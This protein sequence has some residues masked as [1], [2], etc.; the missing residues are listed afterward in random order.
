M[1]LPLGP[2]VT[3]I[4]CVCV[5]GGGAWLSVFPRVYLCLRGGFCW[6]QP[7]Q[8]WLQLFG[9]FLRGC[10]VPCCWCYM[11]TGHSDLAWTLAWT[12]IHIN[13]YTHM[14]SHS[15]CPGTG[16]KGCLWKAK[17]V[18]CRQWPSASVGQLGSN[19]S[20]QLHR[21]THIFTHTV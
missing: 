13:W 10:C 3:I 7:Y 16:S 14:V 21:P 5:Y 17:S 11:G 4:V 1:H 6:L 15:R 19:N 9:V 2:L 8:R 18:P 12:P 20:W